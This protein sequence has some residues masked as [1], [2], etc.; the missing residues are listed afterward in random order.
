MLDIDPTFDRL[1]IFPDE[2]TG[3]TG[4]VA[5]LKAVA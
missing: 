4:I 2:A 5:S 1:E 3:M